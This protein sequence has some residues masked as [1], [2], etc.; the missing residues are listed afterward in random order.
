MSVALLLSMSAW[1]TATAVGGAFQERWGLD[2]S[3]VA[4]LTTV[5]QIGF[6]VGTALA[7][8]LNLA[9]IWPSGRYFGFSAFA[10]AG[11]N[12]ALL[13]APSYEAAMA[14]R[15]CTG[16]CLAGVY[17]PAMK[18]MAT[19]FRSARGLAIGT[20]VGALTVGKAAPYLLKGLGSTAAAEPVVLGAS[21]GGVV[22]GALVLA[23]YAD[24]P[25]RFARRPFE[26]RRVGRVLRHRDTMWATGGYL[27]HMWEL[28]A[29]WLLVTPFFAAALSARGVADPASGA[30]LWGFAVIAIGGFGAVV[31]GRWADQWGRSRV[32]NG[33]MAVSG[34][35]S[36]C[37]GWLVGAPLWIVGPIALVWGAT[38]V[39]D[40]AQFSAVVTEV[41][42]RDAVGT[43]LTLQT[44]LGFALT[45]VSMQLGVAVVEAW[46][47]GPGL[48]LLAL[49]PMA[50]I[51]SMRRLQARLETAASGRGEGADD[52]RR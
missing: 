26:W 16:L 18:M 37:L 5:V 23:A 3:G 22:G 14:L 44:M 24:G 38:I 36:L 11:A 8:L 7:A 49:G 9:D 19:W 51:A 31:A 41:A 43:A 33:A 13:V 15:F 21:V 35:C 17:P 45:G 12:A 25:Y 47:W 48:S 28:Y 50:G 29:G 46:G 6:V 52:A 39:A 30:A 10:A 42:P 2:A 32:A 1:F 20:V 4:W 34:V 40:S 27:G